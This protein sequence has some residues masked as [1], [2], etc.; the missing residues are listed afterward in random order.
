MYPNLKDS[1][2]R[3]EAAGLATVS[4]QLDN[5]CHRYTQCIL[6]DTPSPSMTTS[7]LMGASHLKAVALYQLIHK[8]RLVAR[9]CSGIIN[10][11]PT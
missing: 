9:T 2:S 6:S 4:V 10:F 5:Q 7:I 11:T 8:Q 1:A 3:L